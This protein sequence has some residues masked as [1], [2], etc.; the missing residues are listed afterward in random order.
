MELPR[1][2]DP[3]HPAFYNRIARDAENHPEENLAYGIQALQDLG[4]FDEE[5][6]AEMGR[7]VATQQA[8]RQICIDMSAGDP[9]AS[10]RFFQ[11]I[12]LLAPETFEMLEKVIGGAGALVSLANQLDDEERA[13]Q[14][15]G[16]EQKPSVQTPIGDYVRAQGTAPIEATI[17]WSAVS[18]GILIETGSVLDFVSLTVGEALSPVARD[19]LY[20]EVSSGG[21]A[22]HELI[23]T[24]AITQILGH[25]DVHI[26]GKLPGDTTL[27]LARTYA[28]W[29]E[30]TSLV[31][32]ALTPP[33]TPELI[34]PSIGKQI[35]AGV[36][37]EKLQEKVTRSTDETHIF[38]PSWSQLQKAGLRQFTTELL[39]PDKPEA[40]TIPIANPAEAKR[41]TGVL[42]VLGQLGQGEPVAMRQAFDKLITSE[43][44][45]KDS[46]E[47]ARRILQASPT[48]MP[49]WQPVMK[50]LDLLLAHWGA[51]QAAIGK[52][53]PA[54]KDV[55][56][57]VAAVSRALHAYH[58]RR[59]MLSETGE[60][61]DGTRS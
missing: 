50:D 58:E 8:V 19:I 39:R 49:E 26:R 7:N 10:F 38:R 51:V 45:T 20:Q 25:P 32:R 44:Q 18:N 15:A 5:Q 55:F 60:T 40:D 34:D 42:Y 52:H 14:D 12:D 6:A 9:E 61:P 46:M 13:R 59:A 54:N 4:L 11:E 30:A 57:S 47:V 22:R 37:H 23:V 35:V 27:R 17:R 16:E 29:R 1:A 43:Q 31:R 21:D 33:E 28:Q 56:K 48:T 53:W 24:R 3:T 41:L 36:L 2:L